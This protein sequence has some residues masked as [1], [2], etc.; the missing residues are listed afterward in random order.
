MTL[1]IVWRSAPA[2]L[3]LASDSRL[4]LS[5]YEY[6][7][8]AAKIFPLEVTLFDLVGVGADARVQRLP[9]TRL[10][11]CTAG[12]L[13]SAQSLR[14]VL[15]IALYHLSSTLGPPTPSLESI[16]RL[17]E[18]FFRRIARSACEKLY[19]NGLLEFVVV[20]F[21]PTADATKA[22]HFEL[23]THSYPLQVEYREV[24]ET[25]LPLALGSGASAAKAR[26]VADPGTDPLDV[27]KQVILD[28]AVPS[29][30]GLIQYT[31][32]GPDG[33]VPFGVIDYSVDHVALRF[34]RHHCIAGI[35][36]DPIEL[37]EAGSPPMSLTSIAPFEKRLLSLSAQ[38]YEGETT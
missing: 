35:E 30:G 22:Y 27:L 21:D 28:E 17:V 6:V 12:S 31:R 36:V 8:I 25:E 32:I 29:V 9:H 1:C 26:L 5:E 13:A 34:R 11:V 20:G 38:G 37:Y 16:C 2:F 18:V 23:N 15:Q 7:D 14:A 24:S 4:R 10:A 19:A 33:Y 3:S